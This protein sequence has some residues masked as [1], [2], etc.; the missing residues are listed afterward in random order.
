MVMPCWSKRSGEP[1][2]LGAVAASACG[3]AKKVSRVAGT[4]RDRVVLTASQIVPF[5]DGNPPLGG[6]FLEI[7]IYNIYNETC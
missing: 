7:D 3:G 4:C 2:Q 5:E 1:R 6:P